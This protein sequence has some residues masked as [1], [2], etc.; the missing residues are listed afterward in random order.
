MGCEKI[1]LGAENE[2]SVETGENWL[3]KQSTTSLK[4]IEV[5]YGQERR[6]S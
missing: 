4:D 6:A 3:P 5:V 1:Y 2:D